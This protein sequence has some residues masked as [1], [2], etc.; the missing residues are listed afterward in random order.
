MV[1]TVWSEPEPVR[2]CLVQTARVRSS[3]MIA[4]SGGQL[5][6]VPVLSLA[7][8]R[9]FGGGT[10]RW[11]VAG[12]WQVAGGSFSTR[13]R[14]HRRP[15][16]GIDH[17]HHKPNVQTLNVG[18]TT[19]ATTATTTLV[20]CTGYSTCMDQRSA[21]TTAG[22]WGPTLCA[23]S[24]RAHPPTSPSPRRMCVHRRGARMHKQKS[25]HTDS[26]AQAHAHAHTRADVHAIMFIVM[27]MLL[28]PRKDSML[29]A[30]YKCTW[31][32]EVN[33]KARYEQGRRLQENY[34][35]DAT[36]LHLP[37]SVIHQMH[38]NP[39][40]STARHSHYRGLRCE[41]RCYIHVHTG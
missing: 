23:R 18:S 40:R 9:V 36:G 26:W 2:A 32:M 20:T 24:R 21:A 12:R 27:L 4:S 28:C 6:P 10:G 38:A 35:L 13:G 8:A 41:S 39:H 37:Y 1:V 31:R 3:T 5:V 15:C 30:S 14:P 16:P 34:G 11:R 7:S 22:A 25:F 17:K 19:T 33:I 29:P